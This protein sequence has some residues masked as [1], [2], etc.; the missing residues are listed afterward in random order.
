[1]KKSIHHVIIGF[2]LLVG[3]TSNSA[4]A[5][6]MLINNPMVVN[7][8]IQNTSYATDNIPFDITSFMQSTTNNVR[9]APQSGDF[10][11]QSSMIFSTDNGYE[12]LTAPDNLSMTGGQL[13]ISF[14]VKYNTPQSKPISINVTSSPI[15]LVNGKYIFSAATHS[16]PI[17]IQAGSKTQSCTLSVGPNGTENNVNL[18]CTDNAD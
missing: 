15:Q 16:P 18:I 13:K 7:F 12:F 2:T 8:Y 10:F 4:L 11:T 9:A 17:N 14:I 5:A 6:M 1:M 3:S